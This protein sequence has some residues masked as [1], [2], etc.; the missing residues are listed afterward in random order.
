MPFGVRETCGSRTTVRRNRQINSSKG[1][2][3]NP[4]INYLFWR[5]LL[6]KLSLFIQILRFNDDT[7]RPKKVYMSVSVRS[8]A[9]KGM[10][11][12]MKTG[13]FGIGLAY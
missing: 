3:N 13:C 9:A 10:S 4:S 11:N 5:F 2:V 12:L 7:T 6:L 1:T 8:L